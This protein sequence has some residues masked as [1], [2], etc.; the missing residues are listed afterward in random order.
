MTPRKLGSSPPADSA[1]LPL[2]HSSDLSYDLVIIPWLQ[3]P[4]KV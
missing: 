1:V 2:M 4:S 3:E